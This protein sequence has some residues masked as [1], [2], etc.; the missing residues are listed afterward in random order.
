MVIPSAMSLVAT[1]THENRVH[2]FMVKGVQITDD[3]IQQ[4]LG[5]AIKKIDSLLREDTVLGRLAKKMRS[6]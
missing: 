1:F 2:R 6:S 5:E 3:H 4:A